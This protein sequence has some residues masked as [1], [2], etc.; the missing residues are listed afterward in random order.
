[1]RNPIR[2]KTLTAAVGLALAGLV[3]QPMNV[4]AA[5]APTTAQQM[6]TPESYF[7]NFAEAGLVTYRGGVAGLAATAPAATASRKLDMKAPATQAYVAY[8]DAARAQHVDAI[9]GALGHDLEVTHHYVATHHGI[10]A[11]LTAS[12]AAAV[13]R[14]PGVV[15][16][17]RVGVEYLATY[18]GPK[19]IGAEGIWDGTSTPGGAA[20]AT[21][22]QGI[23][24]AIIDGGA[25]STHPSFANDPACGF[26]ASN[27]KLVAVDCSTATGPGGACNGPQPEDVAAAAQSGHGVHTSSTVAGNT[28]DNT[29]TPA[30]A[31]P[32]GMQMSGVAPCATV[33]Q[34]K[35]CPGNTCPGNQISAAINNVIMDGA[36]VLNFSI[37]GGTSP[38]GDNDR[39]FLDA[40]NVD[41]FVAAAAGNMKDGDPTPVG[42]V[43]HR[44]PWMTTVAASTQ[45]EFVGPNFSIA[46]P[47][48]PPPEATHIVLNPGSNTG[49]TTP[50]WSGKPVKAYPANILGCTATG[51]FP[52]GTFTGSIAVIRRGTCAFAEKVQ[53]A[54]DAGAEMVLIANN[55]PGGINMNTDA[56][57]AIPN[58]SIF[59]SEGDAILAFI[60]DHP[61][62]ATSDVVPIGLGN[63]QAD[64]LANFSY[65]GPTPGNVADVTKPDIAG[66]GVNIYAA[67]APQAG[68][69]EHM[70][71]TS[72]AT[73]HV[74]GAA[75]LMRAVHPTWTPIEVRSALLSTAKKGGLSDDYATPWNI[76]DVGSGR[77]EVGRAA[78]AGFTLNETYANFVA[79][80]PSGGSIDVKQLN[81]PSLRSVRG[82]GCTPDCTFT[83]TV[84]NR[85]ATQA[86]W[87]ASFQMVSGDIAATVSPS[88]FTLAP[89][90][91]QVL[92]ITAR[93][94]YNTNMS[95][96]G[97]GYLDFE[98]ANG[99]SPTQ[100]FSVAIKG[101]GG[102]A[103]DL[104]FKDGFDD[105]GVLP[106][107]DFYDG[108]DT[109][110]AG[111][112]VHGQGGW[113]GWGDDPA[114]GATVVDSISGRSAPN[115]IEIKEDSDLIHEFG[116]DSGSWT[117]TVGQFIPQSFS[118]ESYFIF[119]NVYDDT[120]MSVISWSTQIS[121]N[122]AT[123][124]LQNTPNGAD[125]F[126]P[127]PLVKG[128]WVELKL[129]ID[130]DNDLQTFY[131]DGTQVFQGSWTNQYPD[132]DV[133]GVLKIGSIDLF[134]NGASAIYYDDIRITPTTP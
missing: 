62:D 47:G 24:A 13:A 125:Q 133:P 45:D 83:R 65:R 70:S 66:P 121:F 120:D 84:T 55:A 10:S 128:R 108:F 115:S 131:Y 31:I 98:E 39:A 67:T 15:S 72:M 12:E 49:W 95:A 81:V 17:K 36:D 16:V 107:D 14:L 1:M 6:Q 18:R 111:Q 97:F 29:V 89:G 2:V 35:A 123:G 59:Q 50:T 8:L 129:V 94:P 91:S 48:T 112:N 63:T 7:I 104:I 54:Y 87:N 119:E 96:I 30:P 53:N 132:Q 126:T 40:I 60:A 86:T 64:V 76:D 19:F 41:V 20:G 32:S 9:G 22:G 105:G 93:P 33:H 34:Y 26:S 52:A 106:G 43:N 3:F 5:K 11:N 46:G 85:L 38:W 124:T 114:A 78:L 102:A 109:Y 118:G 25:N 21:R 99:Q 27:P 80:N 75:A 57:P 73:P 28:I 61:A 122:S 51:A 90:A 134:A 127:V 23:I 4:E 117:V 82:T 100:H 103:P 44:G 92:T 56:A 77:V 69:Y 116:Y 42:M 37:S 130:L 110:T 58:Y 113:K 68:N 71:G 79:A 101:N 88:S 74:T